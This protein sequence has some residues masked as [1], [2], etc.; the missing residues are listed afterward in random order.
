MLAYDCRLMN[1]ASASGGALTL[2]K[3]LIDSD[4][5]LS[6]Q[7]A[8][9]SPHAAIEIATSIVGAD[10][11]YKATIAAGLTAVGILR[12]AVAAGHLSLSPKESS[13]L[14]RIESEING[15]P[16]ETDLLSEML[17]THSGV[18]DPASYALT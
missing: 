12:K 6:P 7:A 8:V 17:Q 3:W 15:L 18:F 1:T 2:Q 9:I 4:E 5:R 11:H 13:W 14:D 10:S 16:S